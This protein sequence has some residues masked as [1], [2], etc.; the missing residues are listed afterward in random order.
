MKA[1]LNTLH[2]LKIGY[3]LFLSIYEYW[4]ILMGSPIHLSTTVLNPSRPDPGRRENINLNVYYHKDLHETFWDT[5]K[6]CENIYFR[7]TFWNARGMKG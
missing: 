3:I 4:K 5:A 2:N 7:E 6:K 1:S